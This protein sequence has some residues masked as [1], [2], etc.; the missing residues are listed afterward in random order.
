MLDQA[1]VRTDVDWILGDLGG[2]AFLSEAGLSVVERYGHWDRRPFTG[3]Q[4]E[5]ITLATGA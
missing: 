1:K 4:L 5:I 2:D 3:E